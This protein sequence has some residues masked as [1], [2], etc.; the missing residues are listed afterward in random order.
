MCFKINNIRTYNT[1]IYG[2]Y[3]QLFHI[4]KNFQEKYI[5]EKD[6]Y[7][8][9]GFV[10]REME[11][12]HPKK[13]APQ[14][15]NINKTQLQC[16]DEILQYISQKGIKIIFVQTPVTTGLYNSYSNKNEFDS[17]IKSKKILYFNFNEFMRLGDSLYFYD[18]DHLNQNGV[19]VFNS[20]LIEM[21]K[22]ADNK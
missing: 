21:I 17:L 7:V 13:Y 9:G 22:N 20:R 16:F 4:N 8:K 1:L 18:A 10:E 19:K 12:Y 2:L 5:K 6:I 11:Y 3:K 15:L 14:K